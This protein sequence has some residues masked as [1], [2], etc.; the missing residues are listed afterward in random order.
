[1]TCPMSAPERGSLEICVDTADGLA[2]A[3]LH[4]DRI[5]LCSALDLGGLTPSPGLLA[6]V[7][8]SRV[9]VHAMIRP[10]AGG[11]ALSNAEIA[12]CLADI[13]A[14][15]HAG[16][17]GVVIGASLGNGLDVS[18]LRQ[19]VA[20]A[21]DLEVTLH[22]VIDRV[23]NP[24]S[25]LDAAIALG[26]GRVLT[27]GG[28]LRAVDGIAV[29]KTLHSRS[30]GRITIMAGSGVTSATLRTIAG[31]TGIRHF[32]ASCST[33]VPAD[34]MDMKMGFAAATLSRTDAAKIAALKRAL[35]AL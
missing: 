27:S 6:L 1:M 2:A 10:R 32:H 33:Q 8:T 28:A 17:A 34:P 31:G 18:A 23:A 21:G 35:L 4:A 13:A 30:A 14:A 5:E 19:M 20:A 11:F 22:R 9:P 12:A 7:R 15:R 3:Q 24:A 25:A 26:I 16:C 29:L